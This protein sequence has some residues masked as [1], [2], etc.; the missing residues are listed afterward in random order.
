M[1]KLALIHQHQGRWY[2]VKKLHVQMIEAMKTTLGADHRNIIIASGN[3][4][5]TYCFQGR[6]DEAE[7]LLMKVIEI[8]QTTLRAD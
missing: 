6:W 1:V 5:T 7:R 2:D 4:A 8:Q 3:L